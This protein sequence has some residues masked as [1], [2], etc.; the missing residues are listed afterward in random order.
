L[1]VVCRAREINSE[2]TLLASLKKHDKT[3]NKSNNKQN[4]DQGSQTSDGSQDGQTSLEKNDI[5]SITFKKYTAVL[6]VDE[7]AI[8][9]A[10]THVDRH[11]ILG[12]A[13][14]GSSPGGEPENEHQCVK[15]EDSD[16]VV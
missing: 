13:R 14:G 4:P 5:L 7:T 8:I 11:N 1:V 9:D 2:T 16:D 6:A 10:V 3:P 15:A 12:S